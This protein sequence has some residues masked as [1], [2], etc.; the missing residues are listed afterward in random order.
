MR[1]S[2]RCRLASS[3]TYNWPWYALNMLECRISTKLVH[4]SRGFNVRQSRTFFV[5][6]ACFG[7]ACSCAAKSL[8][9]RRTVFC[10]VL[11]HLL[12]FVLPGGFFKKISAAAVCRKVGCW[13]SRSSQCGSATPLY[14]YCRHYHHNH[15]HH[16]SH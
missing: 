1:V 7:I 14:F 11:S 4:C 12:F 3:L 9:I 5:G 15:H 16:H 10:L 8:D 6:S 2:E 13:H